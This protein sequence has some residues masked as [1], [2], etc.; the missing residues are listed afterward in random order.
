MRSSFLWAILLTKLAGVV[1]W[2]V[3]PP[4]VAAVLFFGPD[5]AVVYQLLVPSSQQLCQVVR[6]FETSRREIW[7]TIDDG[8]DSEDTPRI[9]DLLDQ[10]GARATFFMIGARAERYPG[11]VAEVVRRGHDVG[12]HTYSHPVGT[13]WCAGPRE[14]ER[15]IVDGLRALGAAAAAA[16]TFRA[17]VGIK[18][19][20]LA[21]VLERHDLRCVG[22]DVRAFDARA[23]HP[24]PVAVRVLRRVRPGAIILMHEGPQM[25][26]ATRVNALALVLK[27]LRDQ[28][29]ACVVPPA[30]KWR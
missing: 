15:Q 24:D 4:G 9:L 6:R 28:G 7:L 13:F 23:R 21:R 1:G 16:R 29:Y 14:T 12:C 22:W 25:F 5:F 10:H 2:W 8:P 17:P 19:L 20:F 18:S 27:G 11:L 3:M 26:P 30:A